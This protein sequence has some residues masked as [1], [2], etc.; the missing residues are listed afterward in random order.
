MELR[1]IRAE[2]Q[3]AALLEQAKQEYDMLVE[4]PFLASILTLL[5]SNPYPS[6][7]VVMDLLNEQNAEILDYDYYGENVAVLHV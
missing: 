1:V 3:Y 4:L 6:F 7:E 5:K 2:L